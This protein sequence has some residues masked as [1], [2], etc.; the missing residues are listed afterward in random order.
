MVFNSTDK[1]EVSSFIGTKFTHS[2]NVDI[3]MSQPTLID[4]II[5]LL[6]LEDDSKK[7]KTP[8]VHPPLQP[9]KHRSKSKETWSYRS[10]I[11]MLIYLAR[12][13]RPDI[14]YVVYMCARFKSEPRTS[15]YNAVK[16]IG[17]YLL[18]THDK[19]TTF[20]P[21]S[22]LTKLECYVD[23]DIAG[24]YKKDSSDDPN[25]V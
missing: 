7:Y 6:G 25:S 11:G 14:E 17:C 3:N 5:N 10:A 1:G 13:T 24:A 4:S 15:H 19:G 16:R 23:A 21:N 2:E 9:Y 12:N 18:Q 20:S 22:D 8:A